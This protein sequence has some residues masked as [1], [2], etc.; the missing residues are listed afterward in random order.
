MSE[1]FFNNSLNTNFNR[2]FGFNILPERTMKQVK[3][4]AKNLL[5]DV[6][7]PITEIGTG[8][9]AVLDGSIHRQ[10]N[11]YNKIINAVNNN[12]AAVDKNLYRSLDIKS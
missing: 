7:K 3:E 10:L 2:S 9:E 5:K 11:T 1:N 4:S 6:F 12:M 8:K